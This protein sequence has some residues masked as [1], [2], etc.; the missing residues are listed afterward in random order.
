MWW[1]CMMIHMIRFPRLEE[2]LEL[3]AWVKSSFRETGIPLI[4]AGKLCVN[5]CVCNFICVCVWEDC[6]KRALNV[7]PTFIRL[8]YLWLA[9]VTLRAVHHVPLEIRQSVSPPSWCVCVERVVGAQFSFCC[10]PVGQKKHSIH[11][12]RFDVFS[13][14]TKGYESELVAVE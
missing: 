10:I 2:H 1:Y 13:C 7:F 5:V 9:V 12:C 11:W 8:I 6:D 3:E 4:S 14:E